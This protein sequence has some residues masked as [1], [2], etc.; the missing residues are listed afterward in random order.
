MDVY[1]RVCEH[2]AADDCVE[3]IECALTGRQ[4]AELLA[5]TTRTRGTAPLDAVARS[6]EPVQ[7]ASDPERALAVDRRDRALRAALSRLPAEDALIVSLRF[8]DGL[9]QAQVADALG[10]SLTA[11]RER[12]ILAALRAELERLGVND[13]GST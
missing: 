10:A 13:A 9:S 2:L 1:V 11:S 5:L 6:D 7:T 8:L 3:G 12:A 4:R